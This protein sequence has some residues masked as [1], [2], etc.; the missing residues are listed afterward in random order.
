MIIV[1]YAC[2]FPFRLDCCCK[3]IPKGT[4]IMTRR[5]QLCPTEVL[6]SDRTSANLF[7]LSFTPTLSSSVYISDW[8]WALGALSLSNLT[9]YSFS[10]WDFVCSC[11]CFFYTNEFFLFYSC[12]THWS[13]VHNNHV[14]SIY[15]KI[16][17]KRRSKED[18]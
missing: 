1:L 8:T 2:R 6:V 12:H 14:I 18:L 10:E 5:H 4:L 9:T 13:F 17:S 15:A 3:V 11:F 16:Q 7:V